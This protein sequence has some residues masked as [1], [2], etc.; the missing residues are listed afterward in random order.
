MV[1]IRHNKEKFSAKWENLGEE[2]KELL[3]KIHDQMYQKALQA[4]ADH[5]KNVDN[6]K[7][8]MSSLADRNIV[9]ADWCDTV[10]CEEKIKAQSKE[11]S[12]EAMAEMN[13]EESALTGS[14]KTLCI[15]YTMGR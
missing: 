3:P 10:A 2:M 5:M 9:L 11:E 14:A 15:P 8:F 13:E 6:W 7:D 1:A 4:R 12:L